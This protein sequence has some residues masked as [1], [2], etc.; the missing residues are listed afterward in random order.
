MR[1]H[2]KLENN[3]YG[4]NNCKYFINEKG[5]KFTFKR[6]RLIDWVVCL[7]EVK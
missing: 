4:S 5:T 1:K 3:I 2:G 6:Q 7:Q